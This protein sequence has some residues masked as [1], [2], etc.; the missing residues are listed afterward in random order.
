M[1][2]ATPLPTKD[3]SKQRALRIRLDYHRGR[4]PAPSKYVWT[5]LA[6]FAAAAYVGLLGIAGKRA[7]GQLSPAPVADVH[8]AFESKCSDCHVEYV[9]LNPSGNGLRYLATVLSATRSGHV[10]APGSAGHSGCIKCHRQE[11]GPHHANQLP[12]D[13]P[14]CAE[15]HAEHRG[16][17]ADLARVNDQ[18]CTSCHQN[19]AAHRT[20]SEFVSAIEDVKSFA[21]LAAGEYSHP[22]FRSLPKTDD[23]NFKFNHE[24]HLLPGQWPP[25][26]KPGG[27]WTL[28][29]IPEEQRGDYRAAP[30]SQLVQLECASCHEAEAGNTDRR[31]GAHFLPVSYERHCRACHSLQVLDQRQQVVNI[32]HGLK[33]SELRDLL[34][35]LA[36]SQSNS[37]SK[38]AARGLSP[39]SPIPGKTQGNNLAQNLADRALPDAWHRRLFQEACLKCH[40][41]P[42]LV[43][44]EPTEI[45]PPRI[46]QRW[47]AH[48]HFDHGA[49]QAW[50]DCRDCHAGAFASDNAGKP[51]LDDFRVLIP[52]IDNCVRCHA[53]ASQHP[54]FRSTARFDCAECHRYHAA[55]AP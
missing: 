51:P 38:V 53:R 21:R 54:T 35:G 9:P 36:A 3:S 43:L 16:R 15:C 47:F 46:P 23:N 49:H 25:D 28:G 45:V 32:R 13:L 19:I 22:P 4:T 18:A 44:A 55:G 37:P 41:E 40:Y 42:S 8:S 30:G 2:A 24:L 12:Q 17:T 1:M 10:I 33:K 14:S 29:R 7:A 48:A 31:A 26:G 5:L 39:N 6:V 34:A 20:R 11:T 52:D 50:A 27:A